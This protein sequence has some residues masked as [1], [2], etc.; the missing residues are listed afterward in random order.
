MNADFLLVLLRQALTTSS[1]EPTGGAWRSSS[2]PSGS[3][4]QS[5]TPTDCIS[6]GTR[7]T[8]GIAVFLSYLR[9]AVTRFRV[10]VVCLAALSI[11]DVAGQSAKID[12]SAIGPKVGERVPEFSGA[13]QFGTRHTLASSMGARGAM[14]VFFRSA[15]W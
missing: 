8:L 3:D 12:T 1:S 7:R 10:L 9:P 6:H 2:W 5:R 4:R 13:D 11:A 15:D 14:L